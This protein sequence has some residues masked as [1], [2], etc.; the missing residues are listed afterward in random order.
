MS[1]NDDT[2]IVSSV[3]GSCDPTPDSTVV[4]ARSAANKVSV[5]Q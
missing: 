4:I 1:S 2:A 3:Q 5:Y